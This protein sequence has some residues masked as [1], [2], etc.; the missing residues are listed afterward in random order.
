MGRRAG[1]VIPGVF[2]TLCFINACKTV[3]G[4]RE[5]RAQKGKY[6]TD[7]RVSVWRVRLDLYS[8]R[9]DPVMRPT[10]AVQ[11]R[12]GASPGYRFWCLALC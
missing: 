12:Q 11:P 6:G 3:Q 10:D 1:D 8:V 7:M 4:V 2:A 5:E 9:T